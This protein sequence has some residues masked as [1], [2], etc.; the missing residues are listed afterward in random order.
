M[1]KYYKNKL[2]RILKQID[3]DLSKDYISYY[4]I[5]NFLNYTNNKNYKKLKKYLYNKWLSKKYII[6]NYDKIEWALY[7]YTPAF[8]SIFW[9]KH[10]FVFRH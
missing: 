6:D 4:S 9:V 3:I 7:D 10:S 5:K 2:N 1:K 8:C